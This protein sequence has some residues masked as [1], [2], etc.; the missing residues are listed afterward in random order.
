MAKPIK[1]IYVSR[2]TDRNYKSRVWIMDP[3]FGIRIGKILV[4]KVKDGP[5]VTTF[6]HRQ[7]FL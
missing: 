3:D 7:L 4:M 1:M 5:R 2:I 6:L